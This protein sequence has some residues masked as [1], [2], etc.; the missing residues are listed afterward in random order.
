MKTLLPA[1]AALLVIALALL[2]V[3]Q[4]D[5]GEHAHARF[6]D[7]LWE[8]RQLDAGFNETLLRARFSL[9]KTYDD[10]ETGR[11]RGAEL[12]ERLDHVPPFVTS[13]AGAE[14]VRLVGE[15]RALVARRHE[16]TER[17]K[18]KNA[19][20]ANSRRYLPVATEQLMSELHTN[21]RD[22]ELATVVNRLTRSLLAEPDSSATRERAA[23]LRRWIE[24]NADHPQAAFV[25]GL[26]LHGNALLLGST[27]LDA[28]TAEILALPTAGVTSRLLQVYEAEVA[29]ALIRA[30]HY[31]HLLY[32]VVAGLFAG[33]IYVL[34]AQ[35]TAN[36]RLAR[37]VRRRTHQLAESE[38]RFRTLASAAPIGIFLTD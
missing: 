7:A 4:Q 24:A 21:E 35:R 14:I 1:A 23:A 36:R 26:E 32:L 9:L 11:R 16:L 19:V 13:G 29:R 34:W 5:L 38:R 31:R 10:F 20:V 6:Q 33:G 28:L 8:A 27:E 25:A 2:Y 37:N 22:R 3:R 17:F 18:S 15:Y 12:L 30:Q